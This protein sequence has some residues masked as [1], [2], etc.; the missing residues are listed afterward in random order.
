M[1]RQSCRIHPQQQVGMALKVSIVTVSYNSAAT[2]EETILSVL[3][4]VYPGIEYIVIDGGSNDGTLDIIRKY[5]DSISYWVS[6]PD[7]GIY[8]A[9]NK[10]IAAATGDFIQFLNTGDCLADK[11]AV[12]TFVSHIDPD[13]DIAYGDLLCR[14]SVGDY[15]QE[16]PAL[17]TMRRY[18]VIPHPATL[19]RLSFHKGMPFDTSFKIAADYDFFYKALYLKKAVFQYIPL[20]LSVYDAETGAS[21]DRFIENWR[22]CRRIWGRNPSPAIWAD[23]IKAL[24]IWWLRNMMGH[25]VPKSEV[26]SHVVE[27]RRRKRS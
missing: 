1:G 10:G 24:M 7:G 21:K 3:G 16:R 19:V 23:R 26:T 4:Q 11:D 2:I 8:D 27:K 25:I 9:M 12:A 17:S 13:T 15:L 6:E 14:T 18:D 5:S 20:T 22:E